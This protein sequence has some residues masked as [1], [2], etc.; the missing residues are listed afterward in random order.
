MDENWIENNNPH[1]DVDKASAYFEQAWRNAKPLADKGDAMAQW[2]V[3]YELLWNRAPVTQ[4]DHEN[5]HVRDSKARAWI[6]QAAEGGYATAQTF[7]ANNSPPDEGIEWARKAV[8]QW[9][10]G[11][12]LALGRIYQKKGDDQH[13]ISWL[14][15][16]AKMN[17][18][19]ASRALYSQYHITVGNPKLD[20]LAGG[21]LNPRGET[22][23]SVEMRAG[24]D[25][26][27]KG[28]SVVGAIMSVEAIMIANL[29]PGVAEKNLREAQR[30]QQ[31]EDDKKR[32]RCLGKPDP[33]F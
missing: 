27:V 13:A 29:P 4:T 8:A 2:V 32:F 28:L 17:S 5:I 9:S 6:R 24:K 15:A 26:L 3:G 19:S 16:A 18:V 21:R 31:E 20:W 12:M 22:Q 23:R 33:C 11:G 30:I 1:Y 25:P 7:V 10:S 14:T